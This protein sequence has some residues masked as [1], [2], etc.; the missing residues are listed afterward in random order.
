MLNLCLGPVYSFEGFLF[1]LGFHSDVLVLFF[2]FCLSCAD[3]KHIHLLSVHWKAGIDVEPVHNFL[4]G[5]VIGFFVKC[6]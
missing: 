2:A 5:F 6:E 3:T 4:W 1:F